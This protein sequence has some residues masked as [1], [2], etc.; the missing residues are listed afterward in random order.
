[1]TT[2]MAIASL[3]CFETA[4]L[5]VSWGTMGCV[6]VHVRFTHGSSRVRWGLRGWRLVRFIDLD[7]NLNQRD[8]RGN[9]IGWNA[10]SE[11]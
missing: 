7:G 1:M 4:S 11:A 3:E 9:D 2:H 6:L 10:Y 5:C 8:D